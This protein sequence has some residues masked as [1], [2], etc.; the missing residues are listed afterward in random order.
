MSRHPADKPSENDTYAEDN[1]HFVSEHSVPKSL[2]LQLI[3]VTR[4]RCSY[5]QVSYYVKHELALVPDKVDPMKVV[6]LR[7][8]RLIIREYLQPAVIDWAHEGHQG[9]VKTKRLLREKVWF[10]GID[11]KAERFITCY[12]VV[13]S[14]CRSLWT[15]SE[16]QTRVSCNPDK[17]RG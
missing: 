3:Q 16:W 17:A 12:K 10:S 5:V 2:S 11:L 15:I 14:E 4:S 1:V 8:T 13:T 7:D 9:I 6:I